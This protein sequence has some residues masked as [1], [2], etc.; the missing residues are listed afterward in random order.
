M[1][2]NVKAVKTVTALASSLAYENPNKQIIP[3][4]QR[5]DLH[6]T[7][8]ALVF[9]DNQND[10][11][12]VAF[13]GTSVSNRSDLSIDARIAVGKDLSKEK[14][15][16]RNKALVE[17]LVNKYGKDKV[18]VTGH[19]LGGR[20]A[21]YIGKELDIP[22]VT[23]NLGTSPLDI[24]NNVYKDTKNNPDAYKKATVYVNPFDLISTSA[25]LIPGATI[26]ANGV[27]DEASKLMYDMGMT[28]LGGKALKPFSHLQI[29]GA[30][31]INAMSAGLTY[32]DKLLGYH[33][34]NQ[35]IPKQFDSSGGT[36]LKSSLGR[37]VYKN[38]SRQE[39]SFGTA[40]NPQV[41][42]SIYRPVFAG[43]RVE[44]VTA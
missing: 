6:S 18:T 10:N 32:A 9:I 24:I 15:F 19:S 35:Y 27:K 37:T 4:W 12:V 36:T 3:F 39:F 1:K 40:S 22:S 44:A 30:P 34:M 42:P 13:P 28:A 26:K 2:K 17:N 5:S 43:N 41:V 33:Q 20:E 25:Q 38:P 16:N 14:R 21:L 29:P 7:S 8:Q 11:V 23:Y 31:L